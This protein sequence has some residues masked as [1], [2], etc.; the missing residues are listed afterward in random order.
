MQRLRERVQQRQDHSR[1]YT[2]GRRAARTPQFRVG[3]L[4]RVK[5]PGKVPKGNPA[6]SPPTR[7]TQQVGRWTYRLE[8]GKVWN[9]SKLSTVPEPEVTVPKNIL[10]NKT[11]DK[12]RAM[13]SHHDWQPT[14]VAPTPRLRPGTVEPNPTA[15]PPQAPRLRRSQRNRRPPERFSRTLYI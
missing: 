7:I 1:R 15:A 6:F 3:D 10:Q 11:N 9:A 14:A 8:D 4:V 5:K 2:D 12:E 13:C